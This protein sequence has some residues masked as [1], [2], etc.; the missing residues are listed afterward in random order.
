[1]SLNISSSADCISCLPVLV[2]PPYHRGRL[3][4]NKKAPRF[5]GAVLLWRSPA[6]GDP[7]ARGHRAGLLGGLLGVGHRAVDLLLSVLLVRLAVVV[8]VGGE[9]AALRLRGRVV[10]A[11]A[12]FSS[13]VGQVT[14]GRCQ[15]ILCV[16]L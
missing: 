11:H 7:L 15:T 14:I 1:M 5:R 2:L 10:V 8:L 16:L 3:Q 6:R 9:V 13:R 4:G 12:F